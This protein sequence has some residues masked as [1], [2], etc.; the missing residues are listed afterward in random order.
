MMHFR[1]V[2]HLLGGLFFHREAK[3]AA[4]IFLRCLVVLM[5]DDTV[6]NVRHN[7]LKHIIIHI[8]TDARTAKA[9]NHSQTCP[10]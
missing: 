6:P 4:T 3:E 2:N 5:L 10:K 9:V 1:M 8:K 7:T